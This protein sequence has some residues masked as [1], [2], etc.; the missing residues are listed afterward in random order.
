MS[1]NGTLLEAMVWGGREAV[2]CRVV[3]ARSPK[4]SPRRVSRCGF[5]I[6]DVTAR[7]AELNNVPVLY[8]TQRDFT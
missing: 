4:R 3:M 5:C 6:H 8:S 2:V 7:T 1:L